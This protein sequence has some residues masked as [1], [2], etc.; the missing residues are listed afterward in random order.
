MAATPV[1]EG[2]D[3]IEDHE[4]CGV[5]CGW[6]EFAK[7]FGFEC[8]NEALSERI[9]IGVAAAAHAGSDAMPRELLAKG[10]ACVLD[11]AIAVM[12]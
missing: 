4:F 5:F 12:D 10:A 2:F 11:A 1:V 6:D 7:T 9:V 3:V 8:G